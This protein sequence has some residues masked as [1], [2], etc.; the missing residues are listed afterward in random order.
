M[1]FPLIFPLVLGLKGIGPSVVH[2]YMYL[3]CTPIR[4]CAVNT[5]VLVH[6]MYMYMYPVIEMFTWHFPCYFSALVLQSLQQHHRYRRYRGNSCN[7]SGKGRLARCQEINSTQLKSD[8]R[9]CA[10]QNS[11]GSRLTLHAC[12]RYWVYAVHAWTFAQSVHAFIP[13]TFTQEK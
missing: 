13:T 6:D 12:K 1:S 4:K 3:I 10:V 11:Q 2:H 5:N 9:L 7:S 8:T